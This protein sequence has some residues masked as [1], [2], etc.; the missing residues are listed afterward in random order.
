MSTVPEDDDRLRLQSIVR[1]RGAHS[2]D[3]PRLLRADIENDEH[4]SADHIS[5]LLHALDGGTASEIRASPTRISV[6]QLGGMAQVIAQ[7]HD[8]PFEAAFWAVESWAT[9]LG[10]LA[11]PFA[12]AAATPV[13]RQGFTAMAADTPQDREPLPLVEHGA[14]EDQS[15]H[16][17]AAPEEPTSKG[18]IKAQK[19]GKAPKAAK[20]PK[21]TKVS[22][23]SGASKKG[24]V[25]AIV[26]VVVIGILVGV[27]FSQHL[28]PG[29]PR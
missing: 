24:L 3:T 18:K 12:S 17:D 6:S 11:N 23:T 5:A 16:A 26:A 27:A 21:A 19:P 4:I 2:V 9:V 1:K 20:A 10:K 13:A 14:P 15:A 25:V 8:L 22:S 28:I 29:L 7:D